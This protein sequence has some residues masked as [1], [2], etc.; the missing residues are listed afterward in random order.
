MEAVA[1]ALELL[2]EVLRDAEEYI[3][4]ERFRASI[5]LAASEGIAS[6][7][8]FYIFF[9]FFG[10]LEVVE[11][12]VPIRETSRSSCCYDEPTPENLCAHH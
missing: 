6:S 7:T 12:M 5:P 3:F 1:A 8:S 10:G 4:L 11:Y 9:N 2:A